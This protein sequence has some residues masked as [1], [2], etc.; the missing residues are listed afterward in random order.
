MCPSFFPSCDDRT[1]P[2][3][4][5]HFPSFFLSFFFFSLILFPFLAVE[6]QILSEVTG[7]FETLPLLLF[8]SDDDAQL[9]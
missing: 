9:G 4:F 6:S 7:Q 3:S 8:Y 1:K 2:E 5:Q